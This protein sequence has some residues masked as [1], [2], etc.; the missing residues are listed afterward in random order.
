[1]RLTLLILSLLAGPALADDAPAIDSTRIEHCLAQGKGAAC[2]GLAAE[3]CMAATPGG[4]STIGYAMCTGHELGWWD[5]ELNR[6]Y[7]AR[8]AEAR[9]IDTEPPPPGFLP[10]P[11]DVEALRAMQRAWI[12]FRD[13]TCQFEELQFW[14]GTGMGG[15][16]IAC[17]LRLTATQALYL[18]GLIGG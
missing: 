17:R 13:A 15:A 9:E 11:S 3:A 7:Q 10:R 1:M 5:S 14:G 2:I 16:G 4:G 8:M 18:H 12:A 6:A